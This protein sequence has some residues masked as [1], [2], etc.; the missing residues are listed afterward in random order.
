MNKRTEQLLT[1]LKKE[2]QLI[3]GLMTN[4]IAKIEKHQKDLDYHRNSLSEINDLIIKLVK[5]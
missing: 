2:R 4:E 3:L 5:Q 1:T